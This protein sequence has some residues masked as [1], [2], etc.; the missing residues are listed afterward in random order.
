[1]TRRRVTAHGAALG[2]LYVD[3]H[4]REYSGQEMLAK[5]KKAQRAVAT[6][7]AT[8]TPIYLRDIA[9][10]RQGYKERE[11]IIRIGGQEAVEL[12]LYK[13]GDAN[14]VAVADAIKKK[15][16]DLKEHIPA[17]TQLITIDDQSQFIQ[18]SISEVKKA[19]LE[20]GV[21]A[22]LI[23][24]LFL[25][26][27]WSTFVVGLS[28]PVSIIATFFFMGRFG[29]SLNVMSLGGLALAIG[30]CGGSSE[31]AGSTKVE[32]FAKMTSTCMRTSSAASATTTAAS[33][34]RSCSEA[35]RSRRWPGT[36]RGR[37]ARR[38]GGARP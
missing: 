32:E 20:G 24:F 5:T 8:G 15:L 30:G 21:L 7:A 31:P 11:A 26:D 22:I 28:L 2:F 34:P 37:C 25:R 36:R 18:S 13:E 1:M 9:D 10:V 6:A 29:L 35:P 14:T 4:V 19:A 23:I 27:G 33:R 38:T 16:E 3:G 12:A 17:D